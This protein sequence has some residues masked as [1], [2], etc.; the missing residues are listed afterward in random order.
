[1]MVYAALALGAAMIFGFAFLWG[2]SLGRG[3]ENKVIRD[4]FE[5]AGLSRDAYD[6]VMSQPLD[7]PAGLFNGWMQDSDN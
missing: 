2:R 5:Q 3:A 7:N 1:M 6:K 4:A